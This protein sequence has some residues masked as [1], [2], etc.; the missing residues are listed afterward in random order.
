MYLEVIDVP[1]PLL[2]R[3]RLL[4]I[5]SWCG[6][7]NGPTGLRKKDVRCQQQTVA[8]RER[9]PK[10]RRPHSRHPKFWDSTILYIPSQRHCSRNSG[11]G[12]GGSTTSSENLGHEITS[13]RPLSGRP[14]RIAASNTRDREPP[15]D[16]QQQRKTPPST[17]R[18]QAALDVEVQRHPPVSRTRE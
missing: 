5:L 8:A 12:L 16:L 2:L 14:R 15:V 18:V 6:R 3:E 17:F 4:D 1:Q 10:Y 11:Y 9:H 13:T 7:R